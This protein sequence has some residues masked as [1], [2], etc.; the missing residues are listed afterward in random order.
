MLT[1]DIFHPLLPDEQSHL[2]WNNLKGASIGLALSAAMLESN[3]PLLIIAPDTLSVSHLIDELHFFTDHHSVLDFPG[4]ETLPYDHFSPHHD[5][6][7]ERLTALNRVSS[8]QQGAIITNIATLMHRLPPKNYLDAHSFILQVGDKFNIEAFKARLIVAG[9]YHVSQVREHGEF[10]IRGSIIDLFPMG[11]KTPF[12]IDLFDDEVDSI[13][14][15]SIETQRSKD[16]IEKIHLLPAKEFPLTE[17]AI[18][19]FRQAWRNE[20]TGNPLKSPIYQ[21]VSE[22]I[23]TPG[24]EY[25]L[26]LFFEHTAT[27]FDYLPANT[28][29]VTVED[30]QTKA[31][32]FWREITVR[33]EQGRHDQSRPLIAP[34]KNFLTLA[35]VD[36]NQEKYSTIEINPLLEKRKRKISFFKPQL[37]PLLE[38]DYKAPQPLAPLQ[39]FAASYPGRILFCAETTV[40]R[41]VILQL[42]ANAAIHAK[43]ISL[44]ARIFREV[45]KHLV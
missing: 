29:V 18:E 3:R 43:N 8:L 25:Y 40:R 22:G 32:E 39:A 26:P 6:I 9:Y 4:W 42:F 19:Y 7:S 14:T 23:C 10:A 24:I 37:P 30:I 13:R 34:E 11:S 15:F 1:A 38:I 31:A 20:F 16:K 12:R 41:E 17:E 45:V 36:A 44:M 33:Y 28:L 21:D 27:L 2:I 5:I 35:D